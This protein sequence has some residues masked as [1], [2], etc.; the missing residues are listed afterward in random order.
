VAVRWL[1]LPRINLGQRGQC[2]TAMM[3][4][5]SLNMSIKDQSSAHV[6]NLV[7]TPAGQNGT[8]GPH[9]QYTCPSIAMR[10]ARLCM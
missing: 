3:L 5:P 9:T 7:T 4:S 2:S 6:H 10:S 8:R 1:S